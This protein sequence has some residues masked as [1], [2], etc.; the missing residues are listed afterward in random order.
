MADI[1]AVRAKAWETRRG[2]YGARGHAGSYAR[3]LRERRALAL[4]ADLHR[5]AILSEGQCC[6]ALDMD[7]VSFRAMVD[8]L[9]P[10]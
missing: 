5:A 1:S 8:A 9:A 6:A 10:A 3:S 7:R 2:K 4:I